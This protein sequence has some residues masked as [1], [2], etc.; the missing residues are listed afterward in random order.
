MTPLTLIPVFLI[1][2]WALIL[3]KIGFSI[4]VAIR[5]R[6]K[7]RKKPRNDDGAVE[8]AYADV[9]VDLPPYYWTNTLTH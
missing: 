1:I 2:V 7:G 4:V 9:E 8:A 6:G 5:N 3:M